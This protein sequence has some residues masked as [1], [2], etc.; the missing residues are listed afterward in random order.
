[1]SGSGSAATAARRLMP[2]EEAGRIVLAEAHP[3]DLEEVPLSAAQDRV[4]GA[5]VVATEPVPPFDNSAMDGFAV[6]A[7]DTAGASGEEPVALRLVG[8]S[9]A[10]VPAPTEVEA[11]QAIAISTGAVLP[12]GADAIVPLEHARVRDGVVDIGL[13]AARGKF[14]RHRGDDI[15]AGRE[16][17]A[18]GTPI[19]PAEL[20]VLASLGIVEVVCRRRPRVALVISGDELVEPGLPLAPGQIHDSNAFTLAALAALAGAELV[21]TEHIGDDRDATRAAL[22]QALDADAAVISGGVSV[23]ERD[24][25]RGVLAELGAEQHFWGV[26]LRPG[27]PTWFGTH[28]S[29]ALVFG[30]PGNPV[31]AMVTFLLFVRPVLLAMQGAQANRRRTTAV[32]DQEYSK[33]PGRARVIRCRLTLR[34]DGWHVRPTKEQTSHILTS[35]LGAEALA[36]I[37]ADSHSVPAGAPVEIELLPEVA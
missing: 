35:M 10:G 6:R 14:V 8:E 25:I 9:R 29:G 21:A 32:L 30:L 4:L 22:G 16:V 1:M 2:L 15:V 17:I 26:A 34:E 5:A 3:L 24:H 20:G 33:P 28:R 7:V 12:G 31:S 18:A 11:G 19:G 23:G 13:E 27:R 37:P 36:L